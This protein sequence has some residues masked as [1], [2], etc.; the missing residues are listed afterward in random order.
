MSF[1]RM[2]GKNGKFSVILIC[3]MLASAT[4]IAF[5]PL[6]HN[7]FLN[8]DDNDY[9][10][11]NQH[12]QSGLNLK[13]IKWAFTTAHAANW[14]PVTWLSHIIDCQ[15]FGLN[16][17]WHHIVNLLFHIANTLL[18]FAVL[19]SMTAALWQSAFVAAAFAL[20]PLHVESVAWISERKDVLSTLFWLL[21]MAAYVR[22]VRQRSITW[23][24]GTLFLFAL[25]LMAKPMLVTLPFVLLLLDYWPLKR[26]TYYPLSAIRHTLLEKLPFF[27][28]SAVSSVITFLAQRSGGA[29]AH[30]DLLPLSMRFA[31]APVSYVKYIGKMFW[32]TKLAVLYPY[33]GEKLSAWLVVTSVLALLAVTILVIR[34]ASKHRYLPVGWFW[35]LGT[36]VPVIGLVQ[37]GSQ[38]MADRYTYLPLTG[39]FIIVSWGVIELC[40]GL[41][42]QKPILGITAG[43]ALAALLVCTRIQT[44]YWRNSVTLLERTLA[45]TSG[46]NL[47]HYN[48]GRA[49]HS[50][51][52]IDKA[53]Y[54]YRQAV[55]VKPDYAEAYN[56]LG[57]AFESQ[58]KFDEALNC[59]RQTLKFKPDNADIWYNIGNA[60]QNRGK[61]AEAVKNYQQALR[62]KPGYAEAHNNLGRALQSLGRFDEAINHYR[63]A[64]QTEPYHLPAYINLGRILQSQGKYNEAIDSFRRV[65][66]LD[67]NDADT[68][69]EIGILLGMQGKFDEARNHLRRALL[70]KPDS[71]NTYNSMGILLGMQ[72]KFDEAADCFRQALK[73]KPE[74]VD[75]LYNLG[76]AL[77]SQGKSGE[78]ADYYR[79][80]LEID[81]NHI[82]A[83]Q[84]LELLPGNVK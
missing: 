58:N 13:S 61:F 79:K 29:V 52:E 7:Q 46:N 49:F 83:R 76:R 57:A 71:T 82:K 51:G 56:N 75:A 69:S 25:G 38:S 45:V 65:L 11:E 41:K 50:Q 66:Q 62:L 68:H 39:I 84:C 44:T 27:A 17:K 54:Q 74:N 1:S 36:L 3:L 5:E 33:F 59:Y 78:A 31:N 6:R 47:A 16:P 19:N 77:Q 22:Y 28:L 18:L 32:P 73:L 70:I 35:Y 64:L 40:A 20:H 37:V 72:S 24:I 15:L 8:Y 53:I 9:I 34:L 4:L 63:Q 26:L 30:I 2:S 23:Y 81:P 67:P 55:K 80:V 21:T 60:F 48:L 10:T 14:H 12:V 43:V 42:Y